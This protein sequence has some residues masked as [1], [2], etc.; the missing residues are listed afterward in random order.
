ML[1]TTRPSNV[2]AK[3]YTVDEHTTNI[4][5]SFFTT[6]FNLG[7]IFGCENCHVFSKTITFSIEPRPSSNLNSSINALVP[8]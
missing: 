1:D 3:D 2:L 6:S 4:I 5:T 7:G 8:L